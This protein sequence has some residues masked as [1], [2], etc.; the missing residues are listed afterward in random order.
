LKESSINKLHYYVI[1]TE[2]AENHV[3]D[4]CAYRLEVGT[5]ACI[6]A[7]VSGLAPRMCL[8]ICGVLSWNGE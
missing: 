5:V 3:T 7:A 2:E 4:S 6:D 8:I 1:A